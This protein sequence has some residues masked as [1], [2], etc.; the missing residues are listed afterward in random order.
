MWFVTIDVTDFGH[1]CETVFLISKE[2]PTCRP[3]P[4]FRR[5]PFTEVV[6]PPNVRPV[7]GRAERNKCDK[8]NRILR[9]TRELFRRK[10]FHQTAVSEIAELADVGKGTTFPLRPLERGSARPVLSGRRGPRDRARLC[11]GAGSTLFGSGDARV[12]GEAAGHAALKG[13]F[14]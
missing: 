14:A 10:G 12:W 13:S 2:L 4:I 8:R 9:A 5:N 11:D 1:F 6:T 3:M 7:L